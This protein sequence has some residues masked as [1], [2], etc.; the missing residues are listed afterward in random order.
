MKHLAFLITFILCSIRWSAAQDLVQVTG[1]TMTSDSLDIVP[2]ITIRINSADY[3]E[4]SNYNG[5]F[6]LVCRRGDTLNFSG[7]GYEQKSFVLPKN[8]K[9]AHYSMV[10][11]MNQDTFYLPEVI[12]RQE[13]PYGRD[14]EYAFRYWDFD[15][16]LIIVAKRNTSTNQM[17][18][19]QYVL[20]R[21]GA[22]AQSAYL[23]NMSNRSGYNNIMPTVNLLRVPEFL[24]AWR[25]GKLKR[26][27]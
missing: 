26:K 11:F 8:L 24:N 22:E 17:E 20:P 3:T 6:S 4:R 21:S 10:Q 1:V 18:Y 19:Q 5:V 2:Y 27:Q 14:F 15:D 12:F 23:S 13:I 7:M 25:T 9:G 16:D